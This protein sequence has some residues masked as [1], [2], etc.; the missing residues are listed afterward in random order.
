VG[1]GSEGDTG[2]TEVKSDSEGETGT[3]KSEVVVKE[4]QVL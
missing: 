3:T 1:S 2:T 4:T